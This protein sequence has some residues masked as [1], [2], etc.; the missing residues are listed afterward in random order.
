MGDKFT[1]WKGKV[2]LDLRLLVIRRSRG[3]VQEI[4]MHTVSYQDEDAG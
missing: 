2:F 4:V 3:M 1:L